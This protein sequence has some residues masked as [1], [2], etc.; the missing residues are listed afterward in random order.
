MSL[1]ELLHSLALTQPSERL[2]LLSVMTPGELQAVLDLATS[3]RDAYS[4]VVASAHLVQSRAGR[5]AT[6]ARPTP[7]P[8][9]DPEERTDTE[10]ALLATMRQLDRQV[11]DTALEL[12]TL[13]ELLSVDR[14]RPQAGTDGEQTRVDSILVRQKMEQLEAR[15]EHLD[16][17]RRGLLLNCGLPHTSSPPHPN[18]EQKDCD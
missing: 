1:P 10:S 16:E 6:A 3:I 15:L 12:V 7:P 8:Q 18:E 13:G 17:Q 14:R 11:S 5:L 4:A 9:S 2:D